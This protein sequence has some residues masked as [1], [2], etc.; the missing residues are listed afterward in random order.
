MRVSSPESMNV[1]SADF[2]PR[3][4]EKPAGDLPAPQEPSQDFAE[5]QDTT[6]NLLSRAASTTYLPDADPS[7][8]NRSNSDDDAIVQSVLR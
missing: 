6:G 7:D 5:D 3:D 8:L 4:W 1:V 2:H